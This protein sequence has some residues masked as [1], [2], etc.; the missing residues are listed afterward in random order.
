MH[1]T[2]ALNLLACLNNFA[3]ISDNATYKQSPSQ[4]SAV[5]L[6]GEIVEACDV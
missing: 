2:S 4:V 1:L 3:P 6:E 5:G